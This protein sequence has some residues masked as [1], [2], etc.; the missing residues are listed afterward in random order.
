[1]P[2][3]PPRKARVAPPG[4]ES[5]GKEWPNTSWPPPPPALPQKCSSRGT[6]SP[7]GRAFALASSLLGK[8]QEFPPPRGRREKHGRAGGLL[9]PHP[10]RR[11]K[12][13]VSAGHPAPRGWP[14]TPPP[15]PDPGPGSLEGRS[16]LPSPTYKARRKDRDPLP[17]N[18]LPQ[19]A[20][21]RRHPPTYTRLPPPPL[22][23]RPDVAPL[24]QVARRPPF[25]SAG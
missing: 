6:A 14:L 1:M 22:G 11:G 8:A 2:S 13:G 20:R 5:Q 3:L 10:R 23:G 17:S 12:A 21:G 7:W 16:I 19:G 18:T 4:L 24:S 15:L 9:A 25:S